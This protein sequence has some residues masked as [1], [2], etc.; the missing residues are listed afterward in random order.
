[1]VVRSLTRKKSKIFTHRSKVKSPVEHLLGRAFFRLS[2]PKLPTC[3][4]N[5]A[6]RTLQPEP[7]LAKQSHSKDV[8]QTPHVTS[9][10]WLTLQFI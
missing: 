9:T 6:A 7:R 3:N 1:M 2:P 5:P 10:I 4:L 8:F